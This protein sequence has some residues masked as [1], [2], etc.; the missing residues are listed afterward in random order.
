[1]DPNFKVFSNSIYGIFSGIMHLIL[2]V[3]IL[4]GSIDIPYIPQ[5]PLYFAVLALVGS[6]MGVGFLVWDI[7]K[8]K[9]NRLPFKK[10]KRTKLMTIGELTMSIVSFSLFGAAA[11]IRVTHYYNIMF[12]LLL[13]G[14]VTFILAAVMFHDFLPE[15]VAEQTQTLA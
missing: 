13:A 2:L 12:I 7:R 14:I 3:F 4:A 15:Q 6:A 11:F 5:W 9:Q 8:F 10:D 1:M